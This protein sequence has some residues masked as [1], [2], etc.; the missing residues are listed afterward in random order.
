MRWIDI[1]LPISGKKC[2][3]WPGDIPFSLKWRIRIR[4]GAEANS[5]Y[6]QISS[7]FATHIDSPLHFIDEGKSIDIVSLSFFI[8]RC[9]VYEIREKKVITASD[10]RV[11]NLKGIKRLIL[12]TE[13][14]K[15]LGE[16]EFHSDYVGIDV[17]AAK[18]L[19]EKGIK[20]F[21]LDYY[22]IA[23]LSQATEVHQIFLKGRGVALEGLDL[24]EVKE[25]DYQLVALPL[26]VV[27]AEAAPARILLGKEEN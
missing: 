5:S 7:H 9:R 13:N 14:S 20:V 25:G 11:F 3:P 22:S 8:G 19:I 10:L 12:K 26:K 2:P 23:T 24:R 4:D 1:T 18:F 15:R 21:G 6:L 17:S 16:P 27:G